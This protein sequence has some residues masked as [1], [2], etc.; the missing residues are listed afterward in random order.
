MNAGFFGADGVV[1]AAN[2]V[3]HLVQEF[4]GHAFVYLRNL[5]LDPW[6][7]ILYLVVNLACFR[8]RVE[9]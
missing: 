3:V 8:K 2:G 9:I 1:F 6:W 4:L 7:S 5:T